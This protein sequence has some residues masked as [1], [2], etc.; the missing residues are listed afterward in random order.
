L[1]HLPDAAVAHAIRA[2][3]V[4]DRLA[5]GLRGIV[6]IPSRRYLQVPNPPSEIMAAL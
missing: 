3:A 1:A 4:D 6:E 5:L 2:L